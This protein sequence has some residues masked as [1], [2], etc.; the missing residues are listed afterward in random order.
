MALR[1]SS[2]AY[3][4]SETI[5]TTVTTTDF[6][7]EI[8]GGECQKYTI[9]IYDA[10]D[11]SVVY[12]D[13]VVLTSPN[14]VQDGDNLEI[15]VPLS[16]S[17]TAGDYYWRVDM[18]EDSSL[19]DYVTSLPFVFWYNAE[20]VVVFS[21][22]IPDPLTEQS[23]EFTVSYTQAQGKKVREFTF[24]KYNSD[25]SEILDQSATQ[26]STNIKYTFDEF[27]N[28]EM[29][30]VECKGVTETGLDFTTGIT[31]FDVTYSTEVSISSPNVTIND[32]STVTLDFG[33]VV[34][35]LGVATG[36]IS[37]A[38]G[39]VSSSL[40]S[41]KIEDTAYVTFSDIDFDSEF[42]FQ[43]IWTI[44]NLTYQDGDKIKLSG[45]SGSTTSYISMGYESPNFYIDRDGTKTYGDVYALTTG[46]YVL[47]LE[48][49][50]II[51]AMYYRKL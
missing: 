13:T 48:S 7:T 33:D 43:V 28:N 19:S 23:Y 18:Y 32:D 39:I 40:Y 34:Y 17:L 42:S 38:T 5:F 36:T 25:G 2:I 51:P 8:L 24:Y 37:Y 26:Y 15:S 50:G 44:D 47:I 30:G 9:N 35:I 3:P 16:V 45:T 1:Q 22:A 10:T 49:N 31:Y 46:T 27:A 11:N 41:L 4:N 12:T 29:Y 14:Y 21:P 20:P 6:Y